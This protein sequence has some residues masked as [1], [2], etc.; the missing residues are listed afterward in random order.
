MKRIIEFFTIILVIIIVILLYS[1]YIGVTGIKVNEQ[2]IKYN[3]LSDDFYGLKIVHI[4]DIHYGRTT[5][6]K[7]LKE[8]VKKINLTKPDIVV[9]TGD[10]L[11]DIKIDSKEYEKISSILSEIDASIGKFTIKGD[12][13]I[14][15]FDEIINNSGFKDI[16]NTYELIYT[17]DTDYI[18]LAGMSS[19]I[20]DKTSIDEK[21]KATYEFLQNNKP[22]YSI[23]LMHEPDFIDKFDHNSF[24]L[25][26]AGHSLNGQVRLPFIGGI[27]KNEGAKKYIDSTYTVDKSKMIIS[28]GIGTYKYSFRLN[29]RPSFNLYRIIK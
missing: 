3:N 18:L 6:E 16:S 5:H 4:T 21:L 22:N 10:L 24:N 15:G 11:T 25:I 28:N 27:I 20:K 29:N 19:N 7:E 12:N 2:S 9:L 13:D 1:R 26:L 17:K 8:L 14:D 23:L